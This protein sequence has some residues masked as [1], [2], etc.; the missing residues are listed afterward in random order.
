MYCSWEEPASHD[1]NLL[2]IHVH[3]VFVNDI[4]TPRNFRSEETTFFHAK[5]QVVLPR[6]LMYR[7]EVVLMYFGVLGEDEDVFV[8][9]PD[10]NS[11]RVMKNIITDTL[12]CTSG[13]AE[14]KWLN[15][16]LKGSKLRV[17]GSHR[18]LIVY[19]DLMKPRYWIDLATNRGV[20]H[21]NVYGLD[22][23]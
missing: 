18:V 14:Y 22:R 1:H 12:Q 3:V 6:Q 17:E 7:V 19:P 16:L 23:G 21:G 8:V 9:H 5:V 11:K 2:W 20:A 10:A 15:H 4:F 13:I